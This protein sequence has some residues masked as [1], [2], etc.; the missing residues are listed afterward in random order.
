MS[1]SKTGQNFSFA[2]VYCPNCHQR[3]RADWPNCI[4]CGADLKSHRFVQKTIT[5]QE[6]HGDKVIEFTRPEFP[7]SA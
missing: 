6:R 5:I 1:T 3:T 4:Q 2:E 7:K